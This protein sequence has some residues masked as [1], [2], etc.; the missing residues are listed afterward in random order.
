MRVVHALASSA[1]FVLAGAL[2]DCGGAKRA[3]FDCSCGYVTDTDVPGTI[4]VSV[5]AKDSSDASELGADCATS[6]GV[7]L[8]QECECRSE[9]GHCPPLHC[10]Q[11]A[12]LGD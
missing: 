3:R 5:C 9:G 11:T 12:A 2:V 8:A 10:Q 4:D 1:L 7:G 6:L